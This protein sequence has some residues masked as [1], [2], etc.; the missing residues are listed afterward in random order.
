MI[1]FLGYELFQTVWLNFSSV[2]LKYSTWDSCKVRHV[3]C[4]GLGLLAENTPP[5]VVDSDAI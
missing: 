4:E 2:L 1:K 3:A 5:A